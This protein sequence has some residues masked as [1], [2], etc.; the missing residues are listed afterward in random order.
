M[1]RSRIS[2]ITAMISGDHQN[3]LRLHSLQKRS[4]LTVK[5]SCRMG[6]AINIISMAINHIKIHQIYKTKTAEIFFLHS[7]CFFHTIHIVGNPGRMSNSLPGKYI[8]DFSDSIS[9]ISCIQKSTQHRIPGRC[10]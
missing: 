10:Q 5:Y 4:Q 8:T 2:R 3:I 7:Q 6:V 1:I 9:V